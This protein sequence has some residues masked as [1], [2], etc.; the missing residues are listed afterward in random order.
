MLAL[1]SAPRDLA[2]LAQ[3]AV[4]YLDPDRPDALLMYAPAM[5]KVRKL[6]PRD[7]QDDPSGL[8]RIY[9]DGGEGLNQKFSAT[10]YPY[11]F[12]VLEEREYLVPAPSLDGAEYLAASGAEFRNVRLERRPLYV[13]KLTQRDPDYVYGAR[14][15]YVDQETFLVY[16]VENYDQRGRLYRTWDA[17]YSFFPDMGMFAWTGLMLWKDH[18]ALRSCIDQL[19]NLP[20][21]W[22]RLDM[23]IE[24]FVQAR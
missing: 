4:S 16:H 2:G 14:I 22:S 1:Y 7:T 5:R 20:A 3:A 21:Q 18:L 15:L 9:D 8:G 19:Y 23:D 6:A 10:R 17:S 11:R 24:G 12:E 13:V